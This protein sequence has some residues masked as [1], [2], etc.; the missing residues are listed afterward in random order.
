MARTYTKAQYSTPSAEAMIRRWVE[1]AGG[2][3]ERVARYMRDTLRIG[4]IRACRALV[5]G[6]VK[7]GR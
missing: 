7:G 4:G 3:E 6:A 2:D 1:E 5:L